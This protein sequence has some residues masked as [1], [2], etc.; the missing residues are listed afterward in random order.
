LGLVN[1]TEKVS[2]IKKSY[3]L[4]LCYFVVLNRQLD[5]KAAMEQDVEANEESE[6]RNASLLEKR[7]N[8]VPIRN[9]KSHLVTIGSRALYGITREISLEYD[10]RK[11]EFRNVTGR[12]ASFQAF[13]ESVKIRVAHSEEMWKEYTKRRCARQRIDLDC[14]KQRAF[15]NLF[16]KLSALKEDKSQ[17]LVIAL[18]TGRLTHKKGCAPAPSTRAYKEYAHRFFTIHTQEFRTSYVH[19]ELGCTLQRFEMEKFHRSPADIEKYG[20]LAEQKMPQRA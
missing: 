5:R 18:G 15:A 20:A 11:K 9:I 16:N 3:P 13:Q 1:P 2:E 10:V 7:F 17:R 8:I 14:G 19:H 4:M 6:K 12:G